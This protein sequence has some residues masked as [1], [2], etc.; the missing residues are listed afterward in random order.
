MFEA[1]WKQHEAWEAEAPARKLF[2]ARVEAE[3]ERRTGLTGVQGRALEDDAEHAAFL[4]IYRETRE[5]MIT[6]DP[7]FDERPPRTDE[8]IEREYELIDKIMSHQPVTREGLALQC[9]ALIMDGFGTWDDNGPTHIARFLG[10]MVLF[11][12]WKLPDT[13]AVE[14]LTWGQD[15]TEEDEEEEGNAE[16]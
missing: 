12:F 11:F 4:K 1:W 8:E 2:R 6:E 3:V 14:L 13:L 7:L 5:A 10:N 9:R 15:W 16:A